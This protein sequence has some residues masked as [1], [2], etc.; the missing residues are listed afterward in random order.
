MT[1]FT[2]FGAEIVNPSCEVARRL[3]GIIGGATV[4]AVLLPTAYARAAEA[5]G[6][7]LCKYDP[8]VVVSL[9]QGGGDDSLRLECLAVNV[10]D[11][12]SPDN[13][14]VVLR[15]GRIRADGPPA[16]F[17]TLPMDEVQRAIEGTGL[18]V[19]RSYSAGTYVCNHVFYEVAYL[20][21][22]GRPGR[23]S[24]FVHLPYLDEQVATRPGAPGLPLDR[25]IHGVAAGIGV[26]AREFADSK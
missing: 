24:G 26:M 7:A 2:P 8:D 5:V 6:A 25:L 19:A 10:A 23:R 22:Q 11:S 14:G 1:G 20:L 21:E 3:P 12:P 15:D 17:A 18:P 4:R 9:G 16:Y 13:D